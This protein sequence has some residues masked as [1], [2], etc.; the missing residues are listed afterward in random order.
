MWGSLAVQLVCDNHL[1]ALC[2]LLPSWAQHTCS[3]TVRSP[4]VWRLLAPLCLHCLP[5]VRSRPSTQ[6][7]PDADQ[8]ALLLLC[9]CVQVHWNKARRSTEGWSIDNV[10]L[11]LGGGLL[12]TGQLLVSC[13]V[14]HDWNPVLGNPIKFGLGLTS[15]G[16]DI[17]FM[18][19]H[20][21]WYR[22]A[23]AE[24]QG[25]SGSTADADVT[26]DISSKHGLHP[27]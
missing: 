17:V 8:L 7:P 27:Q 20:Y 4:G 15:F 23:A 5:A 11:D 10:L 6:Q 18:L 3:A 26:I 25:D 19:Q 16:F 12:S 13:Q 9:A 14:L 22:G 21:V 1:T 24:R 2:C